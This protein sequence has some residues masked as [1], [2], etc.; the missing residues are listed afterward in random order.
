MRMR[1]PSTY[2]APQKN[3]LA[4][5]AHAAA[6]A[7]AAVRASRSPPLSLFPVYASGDCAS[8]AIS[9]VAIVTRLASVMAPART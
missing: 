1:I 5:P 6:A 8:S 9:M 3:R 2:L 7:A 4:R